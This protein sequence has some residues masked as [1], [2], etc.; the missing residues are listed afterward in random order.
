MKFK[1]GEP[2]P[3]GAGI[4]KGQKQKRTMMRERL[5]ALGINLADELAGIMKRAKEAGDDPLLH[6]TIKTAMP[7]CYKKQPTEVENIGAQST[8]VILEG[9]PEKGRVD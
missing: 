4:K 8:F 6:D 7:Y 1:K 9:V 2:R 5:E 3:E